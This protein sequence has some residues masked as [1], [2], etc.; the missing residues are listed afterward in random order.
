MQEVELHDYARQLWDAHG[1]KAIAEAAQKASAFEKQG[2]RGVW[3]TESQ[4]GS[5]WRF[6]RGALALMSCGFAASDWNDA[7]RG[8]YELRHARPA[9]FVRC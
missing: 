5:L 3:G 6:N 2:D 1:A 9:G 7:T 4:R 8:D